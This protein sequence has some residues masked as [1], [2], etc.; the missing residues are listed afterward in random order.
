MCR[1]LV[2]VLAL[3]PSVAWAVH[4]RAVF[5][6]SI[7]TRIQAKAAAVDA[8]WVTMRGSASGPTFSCDY[9]TRTTAG[10]GDSLPPVY[11]AWEPVTP[12]PAGGSQTSNWSHDATTGSTNGWGNAIVVFKASP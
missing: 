3:C 1:L 10:T 2:L 6:A 11:A 7:I 9:V 12:S 8:A 5:D 4:P